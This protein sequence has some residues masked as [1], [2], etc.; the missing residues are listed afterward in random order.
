MSLDKG[1]CG[2][3]QN[4]ALAD[5]QLRFWCF[6]FASVTIPYVPDQRNRFRRQVSKSDGEPCRHIAGVDKPRGVNAK[7]PASS[8]STTACGYVLAP[9]KLSGSKSMFRCVYPLDSITL[10]NIF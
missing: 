4:F 10:H 3:I 8:G 6:G 5:E 2:Q 1:L 9:H 7:L